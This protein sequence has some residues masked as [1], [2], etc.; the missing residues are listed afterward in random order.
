MEPNPFTRMSPRQAWEPLAKPRWDATTAAH[1][2]RR[3]G[4]SATA[5]A[6]KVA[7]ED[8][9]DG[10]LERHFGN[11]QPF[12][13]PESVATLIATR[14]ES[15]EKIREAKGEDR[16]EL[17][18]MRRRDSRDAVQDFAIA[19][20]Q[21]ARNPATAPQEKLVLFLQDV[22][23]VARPKVRQT[24]ALFEYQQRLREGAHGN[25]PDLVKAVSR[26]AAMIHYLDLRASSKKRPNENFA[27]ELFELFTLGEGNYTERDIKEAARA[28]TGYRL[29]PDGSFRPVKRAFDDGPK[30]IFGVT[31][32]FTGDQVI[33]LVF[34]QSAAET[35]LPREFLRYYLTIDAIPEPHIAELGRR[36]RLS[37][38]NLKALVEMVFKAQVFYEPAFIGARIK[39][40]FEFF[41]GML[42]D[43]QLDVPPLPGPLLNAMRTMGQEFMAPPN[44]RGWVYGRNWINSTTLSARRLVAQRLFQEINEKRLNAD[45]KERLKAAREAGL[46]PFAVEDERLQT[47]ATM[48]PEAIAAHLCRYF[49]AKQPPEPYFDALVAH[50]SGVHGDAKMRHLRETIIGLLQSP[51]YQMC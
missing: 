26:S 48:V 3:A 8:D 21:F 39:S 30:T 31:A 33:D 49:L 44:V 10:T 43:L 4:F 11:I 42:Q 24:G 45:D 40:P 9:L 2:L 1:F 35:F 34:E 38:F 23:V 46:G 17:V 6:V 5:D 12:K 32:D 18:Q 41:V 19:W 37:G 51:L 20:T 50:L 15:F 28:F 36:W 47:L 7:L 25:Y 22:F 27:R 29:F 16:R 14:V 13:P